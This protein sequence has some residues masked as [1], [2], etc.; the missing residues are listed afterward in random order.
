M[1]DLLPSI[2]QVVF[3]LSLDRDFDYLIPPHLLGRVRVGSRVR[4]PFRNSER[5]GFVVALKP[6]S[7]FPPEQ[8][9]ALRPLEASHAHIPD[10]PTWPSALSLAATQT[11]PFTR[12]AS[13]KASTSSN[14]IPITAAIPPIP[15]GTAFCIA[16]PRVCNKRAVSANE[17][18]PAAQAA[19]YSP[20]E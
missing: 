16:S 7:D 12:Q 8:L 17:N 13:T 9:Q 6:H 20:K 18:T 4:V 1:P 3:S 15:K 14:D 11:A 10:H 19:E 5:S 2:A